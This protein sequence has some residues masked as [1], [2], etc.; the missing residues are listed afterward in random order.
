MDR[1]IIVGQDSKREL[2]EGGVLQ[3]GYNLTESLSLPESLMAITEAGNRVVVALEGA[4]P[5]IYSAVL[6]EG[7]MDSLKAAKQLVAE[8]GNSVI[9]GLKDKLKAAK[10]GLISVDEL[11]KYIQEQKAAG[12]YQASGSFGD[13]VRGR[14]IDAGVG[15]KSSRP[16]SMRTDTTDMADTSTRKE[17]GALED[18]KA[19]ARKTFKS[20]ISRYRNLLKNDPELVREFASMIQ[21]MVDSRDRTLAS[22]SESSK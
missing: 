16:M 8:K 7:F 9:S 6:H 2:T 14:S 22:L 12:N 20:Q 18:I 11:D 4:D 21:G 10:S 13:A 1:F 3:V 15:A 19:K 17:G 5:F